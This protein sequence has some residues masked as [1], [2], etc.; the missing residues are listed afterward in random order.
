MWEAMESTSVFFYSKVSSPVP[1]R[2]NT[3][4]YV[5]IVSVLIE[6]NLKL[7]F[8]TLRVITLRSTVDNDILNRVEAC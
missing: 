6:F 1:S 2:V 8:L 7:A 4:A 3:Q 5:H